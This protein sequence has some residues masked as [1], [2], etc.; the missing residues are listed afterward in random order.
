MPLTSVIKK[1]P[2]HPRVSEPI[3]RVILNKPDCVRSTILSYRETGNQS[4]YVNA[5]LKL[6]NSESLEEKL[7]WLSQM[8]ECVSLLDRKADKVVMEFLK[9]PWYNSAELAPAVESFILTLVMA[10]NYYTYIVLKQLFTFLIP[11]VDEKNEE[12]LVSAGALTE[13]EEASNLRILNTIVAIHS[14][15]PLSRENLLV[16]ARKCMPYFKRHV[17]QH[18]VYTYNLLLLASYLPH[19]RLPLLEVIISN[20][21]TIDVNTPRS[22]LVIDDDEDDLD[23]EE[24]SDEEDLF[25]M[26]VDDGREKTVTA[27][28]VKEV[29]EFTE[30]PP[31][32][33][34][35]KEG[36][37]LDVLMTLMLQYVH[38]TCHG[39][40]RPRIPKQIGRDRLDSAPEGLPHD[41]ESGCRAGIARASDLDEQRTVGCECGG[42][43]HDLEALKL[44]YTNL[45][46]AFAHL[47]LCTQAS[48]HVQ[49]LVFY[50][51]ALRPGLMTSFLEFLRMRKFED[52]NCSRDTRRNAMAYIGSLLARGKFIPF[53]HVHSCLEL[54]CNWCHSYLENQE[55][56]STNY[57]DFLL[58]SPFYY[59]C[60]T[61]F[62]VFTFRYREYTEGPKKLEM[63]R[64][65]NLERLVHSQLNPLKV[66]A[67]PIVSNF[68]AVTRRFQLAYCYTILENNKRMN[69]PSAHMNGSRHLYSSTLD[70]F[71][72][73]DPYLLQRSKTYIVN[74][75][76]EFDGLPEEEGKD[77]LEMELDDDGLDTIVSPRS[78]ECS[79]SHSFS[80][81][82]SPG[83]KHW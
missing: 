34:T 30:D 33:M 68:A 59:A 6:K 57:E 56:T 27:P 67:P 19:L 32:A 20:M 38:D 45:R 79:K 63:A 62:Y 17:H 7:S 36:N 69:I 58:H 80:Y 26:E 71:F 15:V 64:S 74:H 42:E 2:S 37:T 52:P 43:R 8:T 10:Y 83:Y 18:A 60:Q 72:P 48:S 22:E 23:D 82:S 41:D 16:L 70:M 29:L 14:H 40:R 54:I 81:S 24:S 78:S 13:E 46:E 49:F 61:V 4:I 39:V 5:F 53:S 1:P 75:F 3:E 12:L 44:L 11:D 9:I 73:F 21:V 76:R 51:L 35:H 66:C 31:L 28:V 77:S 65:L 50:I 25:H 55:R 47:I